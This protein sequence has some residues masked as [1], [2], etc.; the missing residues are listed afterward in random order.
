MSS[1]EQNISG[2][3]HSLVQISGYTE[4]QNVPKMTSLKNY[5][6]SC[7]YFAKCFFGYSQVLARYITDNPAARQFVV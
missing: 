3:S 1:L 5:Q 2:S 6:I 7:Y 4:N